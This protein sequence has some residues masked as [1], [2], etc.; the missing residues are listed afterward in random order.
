MAHQES[1]SSSSRHLIRQMG[2]ADQLPQSVSP[3]AYFC[4]LR[5]GGSFIVGCPACFHNLNTTGVFLASVLTPTRVL[6]MLFAVG[7]GC[8]LHCWLPSMLPQLPTP[9]MCVPLL[10]NQAT[11]YMVRILKHNLCM[12]SDGP[13]TPAWLC[14]CFLVCSLARSLPSRLVAQPVSTISCTYGV[15]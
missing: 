15:C 5:Q 14:T 13:P 7:Q 3:P 12:I 2:Q 9:L 4:A 11:A 6:A 10:T 1:S 8:S